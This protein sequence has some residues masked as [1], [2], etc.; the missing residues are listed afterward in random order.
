MLTLREIENSLKTLKLPHEVVID[1]CSKVTDL[2]KFFKRHI[3]ILKA[4]SGNKKMMPYWD[5]LKK[6]YMKIL[7]ND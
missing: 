1:K 7:F 6:V 5:R 3:A 2:D 4:N